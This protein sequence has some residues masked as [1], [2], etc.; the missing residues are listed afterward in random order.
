MSAEGANT[1]DSWN[2]PFML[3]Q[4][5]DTMLLL[6]IL[7]YMSFCNQCGKVY[8]LKYKLNMHVKKEHLL[9]LWRDCKI[10]RKLYGTHHYDQ[11]P[12]TDDAEAVCCVIHTAYCIALHCIKIN[13]LIFYT[14]IY[15]NCIKIFV[16]TTICQNCIKLYFVLGK[17]SMKNKLANSKDALPCGETYG[18]Q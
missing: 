1:L 14:T 6:C 13:L 10:F 17:T 11:S 7:M 4:D 5:Q 9:L 15:Q 16:Y 8:L 12:F 18:L 2:N 3:Y